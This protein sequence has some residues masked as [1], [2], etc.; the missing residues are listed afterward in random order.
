[1]SN[2]DRRNFLKMSA[3]LAAG[4]AT[5]EVLAQDKKAA[6]A[7]KPAAAAVPALNLKPEKGAKLRVLRWKRFVQGDEDMW[8]ANTKKFTEKTGIEVRVDSEGW[9]DVRPKAAVAANI[10]SGPDIIISTFEDAHQY[11]DKLVDVTD[12]ANYLGAKYGG[13]YDAPKAYAMEGKKWV[14]LPMGCAGNALVYRESHMKAAGFSTFPKD[15]DGFLKMMQALKAKGTPGG[16]ALGNATGDGNVWTHWLL[17]AFGGKMVD[18]KNNVVINSP[19][20]VKALEYAK[21]LYQTFVPGTLSWLDPN[22]NK[23]FLDGQIS[24]TCNGISIYYAAKTS[25]DAKLKEMALDIQHANMPIGPVGRPA[26]RTEPLFPDDGV[27]VLEVSKCG[28]GVS[29]LHDGK[30]AVRALAAGGHRL[31]DAAAQGVRIESDL[32]RRSQAHALSRCDEDNDAERLCRNHGLRIG[33]V[34]GRLHRGQHGGRSRFGLENTEGS[35]RARRKARPALLQDI[36]STSLCPAS[37]GWAE[38]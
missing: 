16:F 1:M 26:D 3:G 28:E 13:W 23:A 37:R 36:K 14:A 7:A 10:G 35:R 30:G 4:A 38:V 25:P 29:A 5:G 18:E 19:E 11:P 21:E 17:W 12:V 9:E 20:T 32:D 2:I 34:H 24:V 22:N 33:R 27:Q 8:M 31:R 6:A 15:T